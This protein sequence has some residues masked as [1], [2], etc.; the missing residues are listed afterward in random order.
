MS[1]WQSL[2]TEPSFSADTMLLLTDGTVMVHELNTANWHRLTPDSS[3]SY[4]NGSWS[5]LASLPDNS[6]IPT[7]KGGPTNAPLFFASAVLGDGTVFVAGQ[8][9]GASAPRSTTSSAANGPSP[10]TSVRPAGP[11][12]ATVGG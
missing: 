12:S 9:A 4:I 5:S 8:R 1:S 3:G 11:R 10:L 7:D 6:G 2:N